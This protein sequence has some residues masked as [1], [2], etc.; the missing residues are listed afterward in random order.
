MW[1]ISLNCGCDVVVRH[2]AAS[3][4]PLPQLGGSQFG[5]DVGPFYAPISRCASEVLVLKCLSP[6]FRVNPS[7]EI[8]ARMKTSPERT[9]E[10][11][12][13]KWRPN[14][15]HEIRNK[16]KIRNTN[17]R[18]EIQSRWLL[19]LDHLSLFEFE[20]V[21]YFDIRNTLADC[22]SFRHFGP[23]SVVCSLWELR[24]RGAA[25]S[26]PTDHRPQT[27]EPAAA[28]PICVDSRASRNAEPG[29]RAYVRA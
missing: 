3:P 10:I 23:W 26:F 27:T 17:D 16:S 6:E 5:A 1:R 7:P 18:N 9:L 29:A 21:S 2:R 19:C 25:E 12:D 20:F 11:Q 8:L 28:R 4:T 13:A 14:P 22:S 15:K 24:G